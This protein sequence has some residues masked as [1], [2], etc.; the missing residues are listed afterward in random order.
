MRIGLSL[1][2]CMNDGW[3]SADMSATIETLD[4]TW[5]PKADFTWA[6][7]RSDRWATTLQRQTRPRFYYAKYS[8]TVIYTPTDRIKIDLG[9]VKALTGD[10]G[11][12][13]RLK[14]W[15]TF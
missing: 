1:G 4:T 8:P 10:G 7:V 14:T 9:A 6:R 2:R 5:R 15:L 11:S 12:A 13:L 3:L